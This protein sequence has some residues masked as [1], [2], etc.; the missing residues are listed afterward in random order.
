AQ[1]RAERWRNVGFEDRN[2]ERG[3]VGPALDRNQEREC[4]ECKRNETAHA[5]ELRVHWRIVYHK[6]KDSLACARRSIQ[7]AGR[8][9]ATRRTFLNVGACRLSQE[10]PERSA[11]SSHDR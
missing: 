1:R 7:A 10:C 6:V 2:F 4:H 5:D 3:F 9:T 11:C 8:L